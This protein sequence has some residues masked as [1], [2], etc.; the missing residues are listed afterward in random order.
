MKGVAIALMMALLIVQA[1]LA[2]TV[3]TPVPESFDVQS[4]HL[5]DDLTH[6]FLSLGAPQALQVIGGGKEPGYIQLLYFKQND[7]LSI[8][9]TDLPDN[10]VIEIEVSGNSW[11][12]NSPIKVGEGVDKAIQSVGKPDSIEDLSSQKKWMLEQAGDHALMRKLIEKNSGDSALVYN[13]LGIYA[14]YDKDKRMIK[15]V[16]LFQPMGVTEQIAYRL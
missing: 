6:V 16:R 3:A 13:D 5:G 9:I 8:D 11:K 1:A 12:T 14:E 2:G 7:I 10:T 15:T 4:V